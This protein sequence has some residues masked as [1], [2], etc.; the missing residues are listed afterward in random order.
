MANLP[1]AAEIELLVFDLDGTLIDSQI[2][3]VNSVNATLAAFHLAPLAHTTV[4]TYIGDG[5]A[6]LIQRA[7]TSATGQAPGDELSTKA[8]QFFL[9]YYREHKLD[10]TYVYP[11]VMEALAAIRDK[12]PKL[13]MAVLTNKPF[14]PSREIC[15]ALGLS[16]FF[17]QNY[18]GDSFATKKPAPEGLLQLV[19]EAS[20]RCRR[21]IAP[22]Q[23]IMIGD[24]GVDIATGRAAGAYTIGCTYGLSPQTL[25]ATAP[26]AVAHS[27]SEWSALLG[28]TP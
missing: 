5:A 17:F 10:F 2:D 9:H 13:A 24:S 23:C 19:Q 6:V 11:G 4:T 25:A 22:Q 27:A 7:L 21:E 15:K 8:L 20:K 1:T 12:Q 18:G 26:D 3:L 14:R 16:P 28:F